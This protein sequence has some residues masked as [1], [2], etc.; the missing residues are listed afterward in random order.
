MIGS[1]VFTATVPDDG[2]PEGALDDERLRRVIGAHAEF[3][4][5]TLRRLGLPP[6]AAE[7]AAQR[8]FLVVS[9]RLATVKPDAEAAFLF[10]TAV[11]IAA[12]TRR[13]Y[14]RR[15]E[16]LVEDPGHDLVDAGPSSEELIDQKRARE[17]LDAALDTMDLEARVVFLLYE[18]EGRTTAEI[19]GILG[20][21]MGT[22][23]SR[24]RRA[25]AEFEAFL[26]RVQAGGGR[27]TR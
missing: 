20:V 8:V 17:L 21:P 10:R 5:R 9:R 14:A 6:D 4:W 2:R 1:N 27:R 26:K 18:L 24:L 12:R 7:D 16:D 19:A 13:A 11:H 3:I 23:A 22:A 25:R 15:R